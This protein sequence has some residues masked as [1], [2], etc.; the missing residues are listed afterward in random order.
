MV[1]NA[2][3]R[4][5]FVGC[6]SALSFA[7][8]A[9]AAFAA[10]PSSSASA[11]PA[12][13]EAVEAARTLKGHTFL[14]PVFDES[15]FLP[16]SVGFRQGLFFVDA[17]T[18]PAQG[19][20]KPIAMAAAVESLDASIRVVDWLAIG[21][22]AD[23][24]AV[25]GASEVALYSNASSF[26]GG[27]RLGPAVRVLRSAR[28]GTQIAV[29]PYYQATFGGIVDVSHV[30]PSLRSRLGQEVGAVPTSPNEAIA[31]ATA[32]ESELLQ[33]SVI[34]LRRSAW[35]GSLHVAQ[36]I[37]PYVGIQLSYDLRRE[38]FLAAPYDLV[39]RARSEIYLVSVTHTFTAALTFDAERLGVPI[40]VSFEASL[41]GGTL[42]AESKPVS[43]S[44]DTTALF[45][46]GLYYTGRKYMQLGVFVG[47]QRGQ[48]RYTT[49][50]GESALPS[51]YYGQFTLRQY[52]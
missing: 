19:Q 38:R 7:L 46:P 34:P 18:V 16:T 15:A 17:G 36:A 12:E 4:R 51:T 37:T 6:G 5:W 42:R 47:V 52:F 48:S 49:L 45:G 3:K 33:A 30:L 26:G 32:L 8:R 14:R 44:F 2:R 39:A 24:Q 22:T 43:V 50:Y 10:N 21:A 20:Q 25:V 31:R 41:N 27:V 40:G 23:L 29:R 1:P 11:P 13:A 9:S 28:T 35:G